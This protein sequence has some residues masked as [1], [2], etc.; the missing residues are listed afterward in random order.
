[1]LELGLEHEVH[2][3]TATV[4]LPCSRANLAFISQDPGCTCMLGVVLYIH[5]SQPNWFNCF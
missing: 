3:S 1:M 2:R 5:Y 4:I